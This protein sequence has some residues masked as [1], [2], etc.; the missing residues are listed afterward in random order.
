MIL[1]LEIVRQEGKDSQVK[2]LFD[3]ELSGEFY[4]FQEATTNAEIED[5]I[6]TDLAAKGY[7][8]G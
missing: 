1:T 7:D 5:Y 3:G 8:F 4:G 6:R 2:C